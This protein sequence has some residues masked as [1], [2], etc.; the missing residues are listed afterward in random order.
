MRPWRVRAAACLAAD[1]AFAL[2]G[3]RHLMDGRRSDGEEALD[4]GFGR[5][6]L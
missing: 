3:E 4:V 2:E 6:S 1:E 5:L